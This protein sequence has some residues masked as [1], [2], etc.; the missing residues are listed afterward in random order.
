[1][2]R[3][4]C[5]MLDDSKFEKDFR[6]GFLSSSD[7]WIEDS[8]NPNLIIVGN[9]GYDPLA[10]MIVTPSF[11]IHLTTNER[12]LNSKNE[13]FCECL[14]NDGEF[15]VFDYSKATAYYKRVRD[16]SDSLIQSKSFINNVFLNI[17]TRNHPYTIGLR[18]GIDMADIMNVEP[19][20]SL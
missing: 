17:G 10:N 4:V 6:E 1:M 7:N 5:F 2:K 18:M 16:D 11:V 8:K 3:T 15:Y 20:V 14:Y 19:E 12:L 9:I 13:R